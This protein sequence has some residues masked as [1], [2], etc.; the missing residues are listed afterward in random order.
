MQFWRL[1]QSQ[2]RSPSA[3]SPEQVGLLI[4]GLQWTVL[5]QF[6]HSGKAPRILR[7]ES[8]KLRC[9]AVIWVYVYA[10]DFYGLEGALRAL[11]RTAQTAAR[12]S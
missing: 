6:D 10:M 9:L 2:M 7:E 12:M 4:P 1:G 11:R 3:Q 8:C 5:R